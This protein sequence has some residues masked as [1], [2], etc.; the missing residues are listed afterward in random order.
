MRT[1]DGK[2][3]SNKNPKTL[4]A[5]THTHKTFTK[6]T[7][8]KPILWWNPSTRQRESYSREISF[9]CDAKY[10]INKY[11]K[12]IGFIEEVLRTKVRLF[13]ESLSFLC[14]CEVIEV[15][16]KYA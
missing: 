12:R 4:G 5:V 16:D 15:K 13:R 3:K 2:Q 1:K 14:V 8:S 10:K 9:I 6:E 7:E 11:I